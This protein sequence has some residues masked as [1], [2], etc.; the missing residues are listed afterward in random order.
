MPSAAEI[1]ASH[2]LTLRHLGE[3]FLGEYVA[4]SGGLPFVDYVNARFARGT[5]PDRAARDLAR[6]EAELARLRGLP[7]LS[8]Q[9]GPLPA[10]DVP[11]VL[12]PDVGLV[13]YGAD[14][15]GMLAALSKG[16]P[17]QPRPRRNWF[18]LLP[19]GGD[20]EMR[21]LE[22]DE[23]WTLEWFRTPTAPKD[24][25]DTGDDEDDDDG[26]AGFWA[27]GILVRA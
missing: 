13:M 4:K 14:L 9:P 24:L 10:D 7:A 5:I 6:L 23:G 2:P 19:R 15:P 16:E 18:L 27:Q 25:G 3:A 22:R 1:R 26:V 21:H 8:G 17:A 20:V 11:L 12:S